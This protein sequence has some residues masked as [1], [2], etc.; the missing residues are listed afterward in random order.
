[1]FWPQHSSRLFFALFPGMLVCG[2]TCPPVSLRGQDDTSKT[3][4]ESASEGDA[5]KA[6]GTQPDLGTG[7]FARSPFRVSV[8]V[9]EGYDDNVYTTN[10]NPIGSFFTNGNVVIGYK[11][12]SARTRLDVEAHGGA[13][14]Y[15]N[16]PF[17]QDYD[18]NTGLTLTIS[19]QATPRL[20]LAGAAYLTYQSEPDFN[21]GFGI[22]RRNGNYFYTNDK[23]STSYQWTPRFSTVTS[24][25]LGVINYEDSSI[26][27]YEDRFEHTFGNEFRYLVLPTTTLVGEYRYEIIDFDTAARDSMT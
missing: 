27:A 8:A 21:T 12:G 11:F 6:E 16:R 15:Y 24:Y 7:N 9:R 19:H 2:L 4:L 23:F 3:V 1:M 18:I 5:E 22:N 17:G 14:Y 20:G 10:E 13:S 26:G 25:T